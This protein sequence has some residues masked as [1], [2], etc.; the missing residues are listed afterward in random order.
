MHQGL[1]L[2]SQRGIAIKSICSAWLLLS[3]RSRRE[4][5]TPW[6]AMTYWTLLPLRNGLQRRDRDLDIF[7]STALLPVADETVWRNALRK[8]SSSERIFS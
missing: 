2:L 5:W 1:Q 8:V 7:R 6:R 4:A 3:E